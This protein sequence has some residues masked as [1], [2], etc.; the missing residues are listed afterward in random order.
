M[1]CT[2]STL[3][4]PASMCTRCTSPPRCGCARRAADRRARPRGSCSALPDGLRAM[5]DWLR[6]HGVTAAA[7]EVTGVYRKAPF[8]AL[9]D[10]GLAADLLN[11][12]LDCPFAEGDF[13]GGPRTVCLALFVRMRQAGWRAGAR[14][15]TRRRHRG[16][17]RQGNQRPAGRVHRDPRTVRTGALTARSERGNARGGCTDR[18]LTMRR[19]A[20]VIH[21][22]GP[23]ASDRRCGAL[24]S[25][26]TSR[27]ARRLRGNSRAGG[28]GLDAGPRNGADRDAGPD[29]PF[30]RRTKIVG[31]GPHFSAADPVGWRTPSR[32][33]RAYLGQH[34]RSVSR[35]SSKPRTWARELREAP[36]LTAHPRRTDGPHA[37]S[38]GHRAVRVARQD[39]DDQP[40]AREWSF[41]R[42]T[43]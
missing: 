5:T 1:T 13:P 39:P 18:Q 24:A 30:E 32:H 25:P 35:W 9:E 23:S 40:Q 8:E 7:M 6:G 10:A 28:R 11:A 3:G 19:A 26:A 14:R 20:R 22:S 21:R 34:R 29:A 43:S 31:G 17:C 12:Q 36:Q 27:P 15:G 33:G 16:G 42:T 37:P 38:P 2:W 4:Q 41:C